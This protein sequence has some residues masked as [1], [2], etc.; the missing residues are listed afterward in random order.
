LRAGAAG[1]V[2]AI[3][4]KD[5]AEL[6]ANPGTLLPAIWMAIAA[7]LPG[8]L[9]AILAPLL[10]GETLAE[11]NEFAEGTALAVAM[12]PE[13]ARLEGNALIQSFLFHQF[14]LLLLMVPI[15]GSMAIAA[16]AVISEKLARTLEPL[17]AT[18]VSTAE[19][20]IA[21]AMT[22]LAF[23]LGLMWATLAAYIALIAAAAE[24]G[25]WQSMLGPRTWGL[26]FLVGPLITVTALLLAVIISSRVNDPR[27]AQQLGALVVMPVTVVFI[28]Q[29][30]GQFLVGLRVMMVT[31]AMLLVVNCVL[32]AVGVLLFDRERILMR[33]K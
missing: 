9:V 23:G 10:A 5:A 12:V 6:A 17:L 2:G 15:V 8:F 19:L 27:S 28:G 7:I 16:H 30:I 26:F 31:G 4:L 22:P 24:P 1:R 20:L 18:P 13:L 14:G 29:L 11:S 32:A 21:K 3:V 25:V 33:W